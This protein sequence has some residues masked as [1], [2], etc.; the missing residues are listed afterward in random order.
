[1]LCLLTISYYFLCRR[2][3]LDISNS[4]LSV[5]LLSAWLPKEIAD[6]LFCTNDEYFLF[7]LGVLW[8]IILFTYVGKYKRLVVMLHFMMAFFIWHKDLY[9]P[10]NFVLVDSIHML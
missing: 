1:M 9:N 7:A 3:G 2:L 8:H 4:L 6:V 10:P 5:A